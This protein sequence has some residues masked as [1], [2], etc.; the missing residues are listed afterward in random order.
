MKNQAMELLTAHKANKKLSEALTALF[1]EYA[2]TSKKETVQRETEITVDGN[3]YRWC[4]RHEVYEPITNFND[5]K[6]DCKLAHLKWAEMGKEVKRL[7]DKLMAM[8][9][10][11]EDVQEIASEFKLAKELRAGRYNFEDDALQYPEIED[12]I[13]DKNVAE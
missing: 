2:K 5:K 9:L 6:P 4:N 3:E 11:G 12:F 1:D 8:A 7:N 13:Y 10:E